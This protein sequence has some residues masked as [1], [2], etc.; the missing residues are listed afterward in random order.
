MVELELVQLD[1][2]APAPAASEPAPAA[3]APTASTPA[4]T[5]S[6]PA[7]TTSTPAPSTSAPTAGRYRIEVVKANLTAKKDDGKEWDSSKTGSLLGKIGMK[8]AAPPDPFVEVYVNRLT[9]SPVFSTSAAKDKHY[10][11]WREAGE[12]TL[13]PGDRLI[14]DVF[15]KDLADHDLAGECKSDPIEKI[16]QGS[17]VYLKSCGQVKFLAFKVTK[18]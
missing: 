13:E 14:F 5:T 11:E 6:T 7:P 16:P 9:E 2:T 18:L 1:G 15:D 4:P 17:E 8:D 3:P 10:Y 12:V